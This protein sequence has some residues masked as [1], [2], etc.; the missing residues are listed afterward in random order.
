MAEHAS[1]EQERQVKE[2]EQILNRL[3]LF[4]CEHRAFNIK[5]I[6]TNLAGGARRPSQLSVPTC[7]R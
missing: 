4:R 2:G 6:P 7:R 3:K 1:T 5:Q